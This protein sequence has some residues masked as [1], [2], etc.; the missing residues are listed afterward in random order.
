MF[1]IPTRDSFSLDMFANYRSTG[2]LLYSDDMD[3]RDP[4]VN[5]SRTTTLRVRLTVY[6]VAVLVVL[7]LVYACVV[8]ALQYESLTG[9]MLHD[10]VQDVITV[11]GLLYFD[12]RGQLQLEQNYYSRPQSHLLVPG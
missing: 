11:K 5:F 12:A 9:H 1:F 4:Y 2:T 6:Y 8:F 10:E 7:L 3:A